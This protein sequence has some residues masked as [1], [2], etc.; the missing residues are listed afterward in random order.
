MPDEGYL[1]AGDQSGA[2]GRAQNYE[3]RVGVAPAQGGELKNVR[4]C[5]KDP[6]SDW[7]VPLAAYASA[8]TAIWQ[9]LEN[10]QTPLE[11]AVPLG[12]AVT[13][14]V[15]STMRFLRARE[16][17]PHL[18]QAQEDVDNLIAWQAEEQAKI[19]RALVKRIAEA[20]SGVRA[21]EIG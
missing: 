18:Q 20:A 10:A 15:V 19:N 9:T 3:M 14:A 5:L 2:E 17:D 4:R 21:S 11:V 8:G 13:A 16:P 1:V 12:L 6:K 7:A